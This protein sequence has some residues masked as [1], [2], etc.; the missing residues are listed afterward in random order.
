M[1]K[2][3]KVNI[4]D[5]NVD[6]TALKLIKTVK[7]ISTKDLAKEFGVT[8]SYI[9]SL[10]SGDRDVT[11]KLFAD[12]LEKIGINWNT[13]ED[14]ERYIYKMNKTELPKEIKYAKSLKKAITLVYPS[15][16]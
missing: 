2:N 15:V 5:G 10:I 3:L 1:A 4:E 6:I 11:H 16:K 8:R 9:N 7:N 12:K 13:Y 14:L